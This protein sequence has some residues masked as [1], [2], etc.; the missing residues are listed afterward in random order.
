MELLHSLAPH[1]LGSGDGA[2]KRVEAIE[3]VVKHFGQPMFSDKFG[4]ELAVFL[5]PVEGSGD[6]VEEQ[7]LF[8]IVRLIG[9]G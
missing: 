4:F 3:V 5:E 1:A 7:Q 2:L 9:A 8:R 6:V